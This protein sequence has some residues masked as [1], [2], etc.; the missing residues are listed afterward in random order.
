MK[1]FIESSNV[2]KIEELKIESDYIGFAIS[3]VFAQ[4]TLPGIDATQLGNLAGKPKRRNCS[5]LTCLLEAFS[6]ASV[7]CFGNYALYFSSI[8]VQ[9]MELLFLIC[10]TTK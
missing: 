4:V 2:W 8:V 7:F 3:I 10:K 6:Q 1:K 5:F 9:L